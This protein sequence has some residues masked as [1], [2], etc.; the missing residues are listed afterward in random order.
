MSDYMYHLLMRKSTSDYSLMILFNQGLVAALPLGTPDKLSDPNFPI[1][2]S[3]VMGDNDWVRFAD[4]D[5]GQICVEARLANKEEKIPH[6]RG[7]YTFCPGAGHQMHMDNPLG[8]SN[9]LV[10]ELLGKDL[11]VLHP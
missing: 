9:I 1:P 7:N 4:E 6:L 11:P 3:F 8:F 10:N 2:V 5:Y